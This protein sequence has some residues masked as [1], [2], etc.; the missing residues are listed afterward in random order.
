MVASPQSQNYTTECCRALRKQDEDGVRLY[1]KIGGHSGSSTRIEIAAGIIAASANGPVHSGSDSEVFVQKA[2]CIIEHIHKGHVN[3]CNW[4]L[5]SDGD[6]LEHFYEVVK[7]KGAQ[8]INITW[9]KGHAIDKH[10]EKGITTEVNKEG[11]HIAD[12]VADLG[13]ALH[14]KDIVD[15]AKYMSRR[16]NQ[17][18]QFMKKVSQHTRS[19]PHT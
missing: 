15:A 12:E 4:K 19:L 1:A 5:V 16:H 3:R 6:L 17:Y 18:I 14:G 8:A 2:K 11:N 10:V 13:T 9:V 7:A